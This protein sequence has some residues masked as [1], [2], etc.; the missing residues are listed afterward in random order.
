M[1]H[2]LRLLRRF[3]TMAFVRA[4]EYRFNFA[5]S[6]AEG[7]VQL[8]LAVASLLLLYRFTPSVRGWSQPEALM[9]AGIYRA[10]ESVIALQ[11][12]PNMAAMSGYV[13]KGDLDFLLLRP[14]S[15]QFLVSLRWIWPSEIVNAL[16]GVALAVGAGAMAG[17]HWGIGGV[18]LAIAFA[19]CGL[20]AL[21]ALWFAAAA[22]SLWLVHSSLDEMFGSLFDTARYPVSFFRGPARALLT[23]AFPV[24]FVTTFPAEALLGRADWRLLPAGAALAAV[25]LIGSHLLWQRGLRVYGSASS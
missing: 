21:Y 20:V 23:F 15:S 5:V 2:Y 10:A 17:A 7:F 13:R 19:L 4:V 1:F 14:V 16:G 24:A 25:T 6:V 18:V 22:L 9:L 8:G 12:A 11:L 3:Y